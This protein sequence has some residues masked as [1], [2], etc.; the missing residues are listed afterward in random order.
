MQKGGLILPNCPKCKK[1]TSVSEMRYDSGEER[2][3]YKCTDCPFEFPEIKERDVVLVYLKDARTGTEKIRPALCLRK[4]PENYKA[5][6]VCGLSRKLE[7]EVKGFDEIADKDKDEDVNFLI[8]TSLIR[9]GFLDQKGVDDI[10][11]YIGSI[12]TE[13]HRRLL[14]KISEFFSP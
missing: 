11:G 8:D 12:S 1:N 3:L 7:N 13:R 6:I 5:F 14:E 4:L 9:L 2:H 10:P